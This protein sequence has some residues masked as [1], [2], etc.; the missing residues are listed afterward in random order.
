MC[1]I[2]LEVTVGDGNSSDSDNGHQQ[3]HNLYRRGPDHLGRSVLG[4]D[5]VFANNH[6]LALHA[7]VL[8]MRSDS[9]RQ[10]LSIEVPTIKRQLFPLA[11]EDDS[12]IL[13]FVF[14]QSDTTFPIHLCWNGEVYQRSSPTT[15]D[16]NGNKQEDNGG[17]ETVAG[18][19]VADTQLVA[20]MLQEAHVQ[21]LAELLSENESPTSMAVG[22]EAFFQQY[23]SALAEHVFGRLI[24]AEYAF[25]IVT[26]WSVY[27]GRDPHGRR[28][29]LYWD[30]TMSNNSNNDTTI[31]DNDKSNDE[32]E[33]QKE[34]FGPRFWKLAS[35]IEQNN[36]NIQQNWKEVVPGHVH[37]Y[38]FHTG[39]THS[40]TI[41]QPLLPIQELDLPVSPIKP[42]DV[43]PSMWKASLALEHYLRQA[44]QLRVCGTTANSVTVDESSNNPTQQSVAVLFS[45]GIDSVVLAAL[46]LQV[47][48]QDQPLCLWNVSFVDDHTPVGEAAMPTKSQDCRAAQAS[49]E[50]LMQLFPDR[51]IR[52]DTTEVAWDEMTHWE[53]HVR[54][55]I[56]PK[57]TTMDLNIAMALWFASR[58]RATNKPQAE[59]STD[60]EGRQEDATKELKDP[61]ILLVGMGA[62]EQLGGYGRHRKAFH[63]GSQEGNGSSN[64]NV[65]LREELDLDIDRIWERNLG[66][67][68]RIFSDHG[69][70]A[71]FPYL[72]VHVMSFLAQAP[73]DDICDFRLPPGQ[74]DKRILRLL[75]MRLGLQTAS[76]M[77]KRAI[78]FGSRIS[79]VSDKRRFGSRRKARGT[80]TV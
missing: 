21:V 34:P 7:S 46:T 48:P 2:Q 59:G 10:P 69:K 22:K 78:Q 9:I 17:I 5:Y 66:R 12:G 61:R 45:G 28:S 23:A 44:V 68:D 64:G 1:G 57:T 71:R 19:N 18:Y 67:D 24:N 41:Q 65:S 73:L 37:E 4:N 62:D 27:Y 3:T 53:S 49:Y 16:S 51:Q 55:L 76:G 72:D 39:Q 33:E 79:H 40:T 20:N 8:T 75:A 32:K 50:E 58:R 74:G 13:P 52:L 6:H 26:P 70:E 11:G 43:S 60:H 31:D 63:R 29:L 30:E 25:C 80:A 54:T 77:V 38:R 47:L 36:M 42:D 15:T 35:V 14:E 56:H